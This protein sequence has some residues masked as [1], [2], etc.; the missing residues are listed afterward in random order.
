MSGSGV[1]HISQTSLEL[2]QGTGQVQFWALTKDK[3]ERVDMSGSRAGYVRSKD[4][5]AEGPG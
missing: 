3:A 2:G 5:V 1:G 4:L